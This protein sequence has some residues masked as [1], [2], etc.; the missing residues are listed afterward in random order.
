MLA[1]DDV[2]PVN[3]GERLRDPNKA[4]VRT[5]RVAIVGTGHVG[6][7]TAYA[8]LLSGL[9]TQIVLIDQN[10]TLAQ[11]QVDDLLDA[12]VFSNS[13]E[14]FAG[15]LSDCRNADVVV[16][17]A[18]TSQSTIK[19]SRF[20]GLP[21]SAAIFREII[22]QI[23]AY[24]PAAVL[25]IASNPVDVLTY[26][27]LKW[28]GFPA[29]RVLGSGTSLDSSRLRRRLAQ[30]H[31]IAPTNVHAYIIGEH[32]D[33]Q[34]ALL[35]SA[36]IAGLPLK[37][38][39][40]QADLSYRENELNEIVEGTRTGGLTILRG[41]GA[42]YY[43]IAAALVR[44]AHAILADEHAVM[45][46]STQGD[47]RGVASSVVKEIED[48]GLFLIWFSPNRFKERIAKDAFAPCGPV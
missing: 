48:R 10:R 2:P 47:W 40:R 22:P 23:A 3:A 5:A 16:I 27:A 9:P 43:G 24:N 14:I 42:T 38:F 31:G 11:A 36:R 35:S 4:P 39:C 25:L 34:V 29:G 19:S 32:G 17:T 20:E 45:T 21:K 7:T 41:K 13:S 8:L 37:E 28:S 6:A 1:H 33:S 30:H 15:E 46:V 12:E 18:G 26:A 44:L